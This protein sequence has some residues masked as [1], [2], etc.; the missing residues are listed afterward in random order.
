MISGGQILWNA[1]AI[2]DMSKISCQTGKHIVTSEIEWIIFKV[3]CIRNMSQKIGCKRSPNNPQRRRNCISCGSATS[4]GRDHEFQEPTMRREH[5]VRRER[6]SAKNLTAIGKSF[7]LKKQ[8]M[9]RKI[10][11]TS[12][13]FKETL[14]T[15]I[16]L[17]RPKEKL[18]P[19]PLKYIDVIRSTHT[20]LDVAKEKRIDDYWNVD[21]DRTLSDSWTSFTR[22]TL[23]N[24]TPP[25]RW[26]WSREGDWQKS[27]RHHVQ[28]THCLT[29]GQELEKPLKEEK[30]KNG[31]SQDACLR[32]SRLGEGHCYIAL[33]TFN[34]LSLKKNGQSRNRN[35]NAPEN[36]EKFILL[37]RVMKSTRTSL[38]MQG[39]SWRHQRK[40][41][42]HAKERSPRHAYG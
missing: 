30:N 3:G 27:K 14:F 40:L 10:G 38:K 29:P 6:I 41:Q 34:V 25:K 15:V 17:N 11:K 31:Q 33:S 37:I 39:E 35:S 16:I 5:T 4:S 42:C 26:R 19:I 36:W 8:K 2:C 22:F 13:L 9:T 32:R 18:F 23:L 7:D 1:V 20:D 28:I 21:G 12:G 24:E